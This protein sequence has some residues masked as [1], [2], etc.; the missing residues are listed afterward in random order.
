MESTRAIRNTQHDHRVAG[1][2]CFVRSIHVEYNA[3]GDT[4][5][6]SITAFVVSP[7]TKGL[8]SGPFPTTRLPSLSY[9]HPKGNG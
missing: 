7:T 2:V 6:R 1:E 9:S 3:S 4:V 8:S 5:M